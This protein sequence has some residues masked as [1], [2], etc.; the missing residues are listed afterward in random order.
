[1][2]I[3][4]KQVLHFGWGRTEEKGSGRNTNR[5]SMENKSPVRKVKR[6]PAS[7]KGTDVSDQVLMLT[8]RYEVDHFLWLLWASSVSWLWRKTVSRCQAVVLGDS[9][10]LC[11]LLLTNP[12]ARVNHSYP[13]FLI[14][15]REAVCTV[16]H[17]L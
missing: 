15:K 2:V 13:K 10:S 6:L 5:D 8:A 4:V 9:A 11:S 17:R 1:M 3:S 12:P 14:Y 7:G 16:K